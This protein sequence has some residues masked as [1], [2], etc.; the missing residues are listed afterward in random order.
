MIG[1]ITICMGKCLIHRAFGSKYFAATGFNPLLHEFNIKSA[2]STI[3][4]SFLLIWVE[5]TVLNVFLIIFST[6]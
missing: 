2:V 5:P 3:H 4:I 1:S 6:D